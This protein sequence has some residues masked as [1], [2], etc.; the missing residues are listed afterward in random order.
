MKV[1]IDTCIII[2]FLQK[3]VPFDEAAYRIMRASAL[4]LFSGCITAKS[5][6]DIYYLMH[7][8]THSDLESRMQLNNLLAL[9]AVLD[10]SAEDVFHALSSNISDFEDAVMVE[11]AIRNHLDCIVTRNIRDF[12]KSSVPVFTPDEVLKIP[13][14]EAEAE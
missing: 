2:D 1:L 5:V 9:V 3:R 8:H 11:T 7:R 14:L 12:T 4:N 13:E 10:T 6:T